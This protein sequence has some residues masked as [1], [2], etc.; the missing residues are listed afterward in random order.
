VIVESRQS[1]A[2][3]MRLEGKCGFVPAANGTTWW[4]SETCR[5]QRRHVAVTPG[6]L[7]FA[8]G[9]DVNGLARLRE[10]YGRRS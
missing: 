3:F 2:R 7:E 5:S 10:R 1:I 6:G 8:R 9:T 4:C